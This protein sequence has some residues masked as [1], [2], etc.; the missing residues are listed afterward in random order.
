MV[1][2]SPRRAAAGERRLR[3]LDAHVHARAD[4]AQ[5]AVANQRAGQ[6]AGFAQHLEAV[7]DAEHQA[8]GVRELDDALHDRR[9]ARHGAAA[10]VVAVGKPAGQD[11]AVDALEV[12]I[13][14]P[15]RHRVFTE[16]VIDDVQRV[17]IVVRTGKRAPLP[18]SA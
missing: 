5:A 2:T 7:A 13:L 8:T 11:D 12:A 6:Q 10:Q 16:H 3:L 18:R 9:E 4:E 17:V 14:V 15:Q 1:S